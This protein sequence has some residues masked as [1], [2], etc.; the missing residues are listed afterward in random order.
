MPLLWSEVKSGQKNADFNIKTVPT[1]MSKKDDVFK[2]VLGKG[3]DM[4]KA[5]EQLNSL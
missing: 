2:A 4:D 1:I 5:I 3:I